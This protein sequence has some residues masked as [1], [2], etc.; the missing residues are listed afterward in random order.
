M[1]VSVE[2]PP[3]IHDQDM[4]D[5]TGVKSHHRV[6]VPRGGR[7]ELNFPVRDD[8][9]PVDPKALIEQLVEQA[10]A[11][12]P[13]AYRLDNGGGLFTIVPTKMRDTKGTIADIVPLLDRRVN[14]PLGERTIAETANLMAADLSAQTGLRVNC[15]QAAVAGVPWGGAKI[16]FEA[17]NEP[18]RSVLRR[19]IAASLA[20][21][22]DHYYW[23]QRCDPLPS[24]WCFINLLYARPP[25]NSAVQIPN[26]PH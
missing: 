13:Y 26:S 3:Y 23:V 10:N 9:F 16:S 24:D 5:A 6:L 14:I 21:K 8:G 12:F 1:N 7:L 11:Q 25:A 15:C 2:D 17:K 4:Q 22:P 19:L 20:G 18:A